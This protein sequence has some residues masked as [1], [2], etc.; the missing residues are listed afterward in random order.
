MKTVFRV[1]A[2]MLIIPLLAM[3]EPAKVSKVDKLREKPFIDG[4]VVLTLT[5]GQAVDIQKRQGSWYFVKV[6]NKTGWVPMLSVHRTQQAATVSSGSLTNTATGRSSSGGVVSTTGVRGLNEDNLKTASYSE[7]AVTTAEKNRV[8]RD[9]TAAFASAG[10]LAAQTVPA[11]CA[12]PAK[13]GA[14]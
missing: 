1:I 10:G 3:A 7:E 14:R 12:Q 2:G 9:K 13:G 4:K 6:L 8:A 11:L 5:V